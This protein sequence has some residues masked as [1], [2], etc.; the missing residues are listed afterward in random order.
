MFRSDA[1]VAPIAITLFVVSVGCEK[2]PDPAPETA[3]QPIAMRVSCQEPPIVASRSVQHDGDFARVNVA[4]HCIQYVDDGTFGQSCRKLGGC[5]KPKPR[6]FR[7]DVVYRWRA[8]WDIDGTTCTPS[9]LPWGVG[10]EI[11][12]R[13]YHIPGTDPGDKCPAG[14]GKSYKFAS[15]RGE[16]FELRGCEQGVSLVDSRSPKPLFTE[17]CDAIDVKTA[18]IDGDKVEDIAYRCSCCGNVADGSHTTVILAGMGTL[19]THNDT[20]EVTGD[21]EVSAKNPAIKNQLVRLFE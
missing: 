4:G 1:F 21:V 20:G 9:D 17:M 12:A 14:E 15:P 16:V 7:C 19:V 8:G 3:T 10:L 5:K 2:R 13:E 6:G 18:D 11:Y